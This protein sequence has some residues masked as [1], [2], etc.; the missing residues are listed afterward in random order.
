MKYLASIHFSW[1]KHINPPKFFLVLSISWGAVLVFLTP[2]LQVPDEPR[3]FLRAYQVSTLH[4]NPEINNNRL[5][6]TLPTEFLPFI[7]HY[8]A[9]ILNNGQKKLSKE[10]Y[11]FG[12]NQSLNLHQQAF[13]PLPNT[14]LYAPVAYL[15]QA[16]GMAIGTQLNTPPLVLLYLG[17][18]FNLF[19]WIILVYWSIRLLPFNQWLFVLL[20]LLPMSI[21]QAASLSADTTTNGLSFLLTSVFLRYSFDDQAQ[22]HRQQI[23]WIAVLA[24]LITLCKNVYTPIL[25]LGFMIPKEKFGSN[26]NYLLTLILLGCLVTAGLAYSAYN[27][28]GL[29]N[30]IHPIETLYGQEG[31]PKINPD[32]QLDLIM[33]DIPAFL[34]RVVHSFDTYKKT[35]YQTF[36][37]RLAWLDVFFEDWYYHLAWGY[38]CLVAIFGSPT[39]KEMSMIHRGTMLISC[40]AVLL[41]FSVTMYLSWADVGEKTISN[42]QGRY[43]SPIGP[44]L[45]SLLAN[46]FRWKIPPLYQNTLAMLFVLLSMTLTFQSMILRFF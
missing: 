27:V 12:L 46:N 25:C 45:F 11:A 6:G 5:G 16:I 18:L 9:F 15:P 10:D 38:L 24:V 39:P 7:Q 23:F 36:I 34:S 28:K 33:S 8:G 4:F 3:H 1:F 21:F 13:I 31:V 40:L 2:P 42:L 22:L 35:I 20:A 43:F 26:K 37:G 29:L 19:A 17:R 32:K 14:A 30:Q 41:A 44:I